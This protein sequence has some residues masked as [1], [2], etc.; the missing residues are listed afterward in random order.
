MS[1][2]IELKCTSW[3]CRGLQKVKKIKQV[4]SK[5][6]EMDSKIVFLQETHTLDKENIKISRRWPGRIFAA[7]FSTQARGVMILIHNSVPFEVTNEIKDTFGRYIIIQGSIL[8][9]KLNL[10]NIYGPN[11]D[12]QGFY[13]NL[14][15]KLSSLPGEFMMAGDWNCTLEPSKD[16]STG[17]D[18][19]HN[20]CRTTIHNFIKEINLLDIWRHMKPDQVAY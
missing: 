3:N 10:V 13:T 6:K 12:D 15:L 5:L 7:S 4:M 18:L 1:Q 14:F 20:K 17:I 11:V 9:T 2:E 19:T 8:S 16:R